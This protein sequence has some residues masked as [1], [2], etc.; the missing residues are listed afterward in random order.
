MSANP[1]NLHQNKG[2]VVWFPDCTDL[3]YRKTQEPYASRDFRLVSS[4]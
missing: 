4:D 1:C 3:V 2:L